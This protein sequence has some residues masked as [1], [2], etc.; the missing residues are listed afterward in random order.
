[1]DSSWKQRW[2]LFFL[3]RIVYYFRVKFQNISI[4]GSKL[5]LCSWEQQM[6]KKL[7]RAITPTKFHYICWKF[8]SGDLLLGPNHY[9]KYQDSSS[10]TFWDT[11]LTRFQCYFFT[12]EITLKWEIISDKKKKYGSPILSWGIHM[13]IFKIWAYMVLNLCYANESKKIK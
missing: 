13:W 9:T 2:P 8:Y 12:R 3:I 11:L 7:Q 10:N 4:N 6:V 1:M 5:M